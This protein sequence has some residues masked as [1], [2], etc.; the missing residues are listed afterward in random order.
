MRPGALVRL[1]ANEPRESNNS[2][3]YIPA[4]LHISGYNNVRYYHQGW[5]WI[6][7]QPPARDSRDLYRLNQPP[8]KKLRPPRE[9]KKT[10]KNK[11]FF[12]QKNQKTFVY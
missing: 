7:K 6:K 12:F 5:C 8:Y 9:R 11:E 3:Q 10:S 1:H 2:A 4:R